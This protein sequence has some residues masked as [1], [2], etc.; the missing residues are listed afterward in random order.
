M[1]DRRLCVCPA[2][3]RT[4]SRCVALVLRIS[5]LLLNVERY[6]LG[7]LMGLLVLL[8]LINVITRYAGVPLYWVD[9]ASVYSVVWLT[10]IGASV[11]T[12]LRMDFS[13]GLLTDPLGPKAKRGARAVASGGVVLFA[14]SL[15]LMCNLW[16]DPVGIAKMGFD[17]RAYAAD[18]FNFLYTERSQTLEWPLWVVQLTIPLFALSLLLHGLANFL[19]DLGLAQPRDY[20]AF[21]LNSAA[22]VN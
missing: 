11:M 16:M 14:V 21:H 1:S 13:V 2:S 3:M 22:G 19:E 6:A 4:H 5:D 18:S 12:R 9:E 8:I 10:F 20:S 17:A 15:L 7:T